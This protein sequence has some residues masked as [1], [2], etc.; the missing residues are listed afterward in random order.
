[1]ENRLGVV[2][3]GICSCILS[4][5][6]IQNGQTNVISPIGFADLVRNSFFWSQKTIFGFEGRSDDSSHFRPDLSILLFLK[7][8][9]HLMIK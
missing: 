2:A 8:H 9:I 7:P 1:M 5:D 4:I 3:G 6:C